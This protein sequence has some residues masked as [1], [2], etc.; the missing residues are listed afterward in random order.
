MTGKQSRQDTQ[1]AESGRAVREVLAR[2]S[3][4]RHVTGI[5]RESGLS[6]VTVRNV[7]RRLDQAGELRAGDSAFPYACQLAARTEDSS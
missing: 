6:P 3:R 7:L 1:R 4:F 5:A 2:S